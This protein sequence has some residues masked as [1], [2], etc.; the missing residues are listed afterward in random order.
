[1]ASSS[2]L[3]LTL[4][5]A[6]HAHPITVARPCRVSTGF[7]FRDYRSTYVAVI[8]IVNWEYSVMSA[9]LTLICHASTSAVR[10][11]AFPL[12]EPLDA[13]GHEKATALAFNPGSADVAWTSPALRARQTAAALRLDA[14]PDPVLRDVDL[15]CWAGRSFAEVQAVEPEAI[16]AWTRKADAAPHGGESVIDLLERVS[17]W[18]DVIRREDRRIVA[19]THAAVI[20]A[21]VI[22]AIDANPHSFWRIDVAP[23][24][25]VRLSGTGPRWTLQAIGA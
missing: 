20:R 5:C 1:M 8:R 18:L 13:Q 21:A 24:C 10:N 23:L 19:V 12:D 17:P 6:T 15:G 9:R 11:A 2:G 4:G 22:L 16:L 3:G 7:Q 25:R 14:M